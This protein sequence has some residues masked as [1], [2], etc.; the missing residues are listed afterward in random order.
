MKKSVFLLLGTLLVT[1]AAAR[2]VD[3]RL[4][5]DPEGR[6]TVSNVAGEIEII[7]WDRKEV[8]VEG[9]IGD[10]VKE[11]IFDRDGKH[12]WIKVKVKEK[13]WGHKDVSADLV[14]HVPT[15][16]SL[17]V[18]T[19]SADID[20]DDVTGEQELQAVSGDIETQVY[21]QD[22]QV[23]TVSGDIDVTGDKKA[24]EAELSSV[25]GDIVMQN[26]SG[27]IEAEVVS[28][29]ID[30][31]YGSF[32]RVQMETVNGDIEFNGNLRK[33]GKMDIESVNGSVDIDFVGPVSA[34][35]E[36]ETFNGRIKNCFGPKAERTSKY[37][38]G[39]ELV[40]DEGSGNGR[41]SIATLNGDVSFCKE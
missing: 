31:A 2:E 37:A 10:D 6:V 20:V 22:C 34:E 19:V 16:S 17:D 28:G 29:D 13:G 21:Q 35:F 3:R 26:V 24:L 25:S 9:T 23:E 11:L 32:D 5:A 12:T 30:V 36:L 18:S 39:W 27:D 14:I 15:A 1:N 38:P 33:N 4:D 41:V 40:F 8:H 7:G